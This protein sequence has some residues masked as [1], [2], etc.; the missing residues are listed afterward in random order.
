MKRLY[1]L[2]I[3]CATFCASTTWAN[4]TLIQRASNGKFTGELQNAKL[5]EVVQY[6]KDN[7]GLVINGNASALE[8]QVTMNFANVNLEKLLKKVLAR[9]NYVLTY[10][11]HG[12]VVELRLFNGGTS[13]PVEGQQEIVSL[14]PPP[15]NV[16]AGE[17]FGNIFNADG[18]TARG[19]YPNSYAF[20]A[21]AEGTRKQGSPGNSADLK[22]A[23]DYKDDI[24]SFEVKENNPN[25]P[26]TSFKTETDAKS[27]PLLSSQPEPHS[28]PD[29]KN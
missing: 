19:V 27:D 15:E 13:I 14:P 25:D 18:T 22:V 10:N 9:E 29:R 8:G 26:I 4:A 16:N 28:N 7:F 24:T 12:E 23:P 3:I 5:S 6:L 20:V 1:V 11:K 17:N 2:I 21:S